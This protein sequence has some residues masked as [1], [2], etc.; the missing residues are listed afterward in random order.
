M[1]VNGKREKENNAVVLGKTDRRKGG[2]KRTYYFRSGKG[3]RKNKRE[4]M[5][6]DTVKGKEKGSGIKM[7]EKKNGK[8]KRDGRTGGI[9]APLASQI[10]PAEW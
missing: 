5:K 1:E 3:N 2:K 4:K 10:L 8:K 9:P 7:S 6:I